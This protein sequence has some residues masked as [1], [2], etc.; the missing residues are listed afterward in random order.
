[1]ITFSLGFFSYNLLNTYLKKNNEDKSVKYYLNKII[2]AEVIESNIDTKEEVKENIINYIGVLEIP[3]INLI[4]GLVDVN[5][6]NNNVDKNIEILK[7]STMPNVE[8]SN[9]Y[10]ASHSGNSR[11]SFFKNLK[12]LDNNDL[13]YLYYNNVKYTYKVYKH[14]E[15]EKTGTMKM[16]LSSEDDITLI[17]CKSNT[18]KQFVYKAILTNKESY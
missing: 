3:K 8:H 16:D 7:E 2:T 13:I 1:M 17:T 14:Y 4:R 12:R 11:V 5:D 9:L 18:N 6:A 10:L 15:I